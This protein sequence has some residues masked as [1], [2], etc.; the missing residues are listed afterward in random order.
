MIH[1]KLIE[2]SFAHFLPQTKKN[3][4]FVFPPQGKGDCL[5]WRSYHHRWPR[6][7]VSFTAFLDA[8]NGRSDPQVPW[9]VVFLGI[10][11]LIGA[12][13]GMVWWHGWE[14]RFIT[15]QIKGTTLE[16]SSFLRG[17][18][19]VYLPTWIVE[20]LVVKFISVYQFHATGTQPPRTLVGIVSLK[21]SRWCCS[22]D[23]NF[24]SQLKAG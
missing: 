21:T 5:S 12:M 18:W 19:M 9:R 22:F 14:A 24:L 13:Y 15:T 10:L 2:V 8:R 4:L 7:E 1:N 6:S 11:K 16:K 17:I 23:G 3:G 20:F